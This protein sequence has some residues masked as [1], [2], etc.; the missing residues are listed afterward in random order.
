MLVFRVEYLI[1][2]DQKD[3]FCKTVTSFNNLLKTI[4]GVTVSKNELRFEHL[5][6]H[7]EVQAGEILS[8]KQRFFH[9]R[10]T[11]PDESHLPEFEAF[12]KALRGLLHKA[13]GKPPQT[14]WDGI[15]FHFAQKAYP[16]VH[17]LENTMRKLITKFMLINVGL[18]WTREAVP[19][20]V[21]ESVRSKDAKLDH[22]YLY[23][24][25]FIQLSNFLFK[26]YSTV[27][28]VVLIDRLRKA[29]NISD[30]DLVELKLAI[31]RSNWD[32][33]FSALVNCES[34]Y[35]RIRWERLYE[36]RNQI[37]HN[38]PVSRS[39]YDEI[40]VLCGE[41]GPKLQ[42][43]IDALDQVTV[44]EDDRE[45]VSEN[46][47]VSK[48]A[49]YGEFLLAWSNLHRH[50]FLLASLTAASDESRKKLLQLQ[51]NVR[52]LLNLVTK[53]YGF[54][55]T[56]QRA[57]LLELF[58]LRNVLVHQ[59]DVI[60]PEPVL[61]RHIES[62]NILTATV[63][64]RIAQIQATGVVPVVELDSI[65]DDD[66]VSSNGANGHTVAD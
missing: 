12:L 38:R 4:D 46:A 5:A 61:A 49:G 51:N 2:V 66:D 63:K 64:A 56:G 27:N 59:P 34:E 53:R 37:A 52:S 8:D 22:N 13:S 9:L 25:D 41:L 31:P 10:L 16:L 48:S 65:G 29:N 1:T 39:E 57:D 15:S 7:Y 24:V 19:K 26:E 60:V 50:L 18:G 40:A 6:I 21:V 17:E 43:A 42:Q 58:K 20:E 62:I 33:Y 36:R 23:E 11:F 32:R 44:A 30:L 47:A 55:T 14:L 54:L 35:L 45:L 28:S 3:A